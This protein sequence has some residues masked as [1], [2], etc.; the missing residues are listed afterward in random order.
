MDG[1]SFGGRWGIMFGEKCLCEVNWLF[2]NGLVKC[3][4]GL[5][6]LVR[7]RDLLL[8]GKDKV[9]FEEYLVGG[10]YGVEF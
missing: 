4:W 1:V 7:L 3:E 5:E 9:K 8:K 2:R 10:W 6:M